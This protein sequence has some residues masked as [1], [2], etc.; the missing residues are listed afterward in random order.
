MSLSMIV[1]EWSHWLAALVG[2]TTS[3]AIEI[4]KMGLRKRRNAGV[5]MRMRA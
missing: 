1:G 5:R 4:M 3:E 2:L